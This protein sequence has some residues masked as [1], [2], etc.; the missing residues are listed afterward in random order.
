MRHPYG[1]QELA[2]VLGTLPSLAVFAILAGAWW[3]RR[4]RASP[5]D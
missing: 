5:A 3:Q 1:L 2:F 4:R